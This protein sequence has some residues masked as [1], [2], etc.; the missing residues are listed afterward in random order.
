MDPSGNITTLHQFEGPDGQFP[1]DS[2]LVEGDDGYLYGTTSSGG[3][4]TSTGFG[5]I[6]KISPTGAFTS[7]HSFRMIDG[8]SPSAGLTKASDGNFYGLTWDGGLNR[9]GTAYMVTPSGAFTSLH[10]FSETDGKFPFGSLTQGPDGNFYGT[11]QAGGA[12]AAGTVFKMTPSGTTTTL[13]SFSGPDGAQPMGGLTVAP[14]GVLY[15]TT[16]IGGAG[17]GALDGYGTIFKITPSGSFSIVHS[18]VGTDGSIPLGEMTVGRD[19]KLYGTTSQGGQGFNPTNFTNN[20]GTF[21]RLELDGTL[22]TIH[23]FAGSDGSAPYSAPFQAADG[24]FYGTAQGGG[25]DHVGV[26]YRLTIPEG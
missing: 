24:S 11:T 17:H 20:F 26:A 10:S 8:A 15:G 13:H 2:G 1:S 7:L 6:F 5:T 22:T 9:A 21:F 16:T 4:P 14:D 3:G 25:L 23:S 18:F 12:A 19:G